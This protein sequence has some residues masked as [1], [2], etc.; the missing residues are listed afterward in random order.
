MVVALQLLAAYFSP[1]A[2]ILGTVKPS[3][4]DWMVICSSGLLTIAVVE[5]AKAVF[6]YK[7]A[8][9]FSLQLRS[10]SQ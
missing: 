8:R 5:V 10:I 4:T 9:V 6:R 1:L 3:A 7:R 2:G